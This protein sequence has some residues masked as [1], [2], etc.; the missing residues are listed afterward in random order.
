MQESGLPVTNGYIADI[1]GNE[2]IPGL[3]RLQTA[4]PPP[5]WAAGDP[6]YVRPRRKYY[7][8]GVSRPFFKRLAADGITA[9]NSLFIVTPR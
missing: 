1:H 9:K 6:C 7:K 8:P 4:R 2:H 3:T 5:R